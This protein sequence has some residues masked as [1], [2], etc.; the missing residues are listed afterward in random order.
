[1][2]GAILFS[3]WIIDRRDEILESEQLVDLD[4]VLADRWRLSDLPAIAPPIA[5]SDRPNLHFLYARGAARI[6]GVELVDLGHG[7]FRFELDPR[8]Q[9]IPEVLAIDLDGDRHERRLEVVRPTAHPRWIC[10][11]GGRAAAVSTETDELFLI[12]AEIRRI[13]VEDRPT[14]CAVLE[15]GIAVVHESGA[16]ILAGTNVRIELGGPL[17]HAA[18]GASALAVSRTDP[19]AIL[20]LSPDLR[21]ES[22]IPLSFVPD[23]VAF[24]AGHLIASSA[25]DR[26]LVI[27]R[28]GREAERLFLGRPVVTMALSPDRSRLYAAVTDYRPDDDAGPNHHVEDQILELEARSLRILRRFPTAPHASPVALSTRDDGITIAFAGSNEVIRYDRSFRAMERFAF[29]LPT[30]VAELGADPII[31]SAAHAK[32]G[33]HSF[34]TPDP[35]LLDGE[36]AFHRATRAGLSCQT[37]HLHG[38]SDYSLHDIGHGDAR[39]TLSA[40]ATARTA[41]Y[42]RGASYPSIAALEAFTTYVLGGYEEPIPNRALALEAYL[43]SLPRA[44][45]RSSP[46]VELLRR[47]TDAFVRAGCSFCHRFP[48]FTDLAQ[49]PEGF[50]F[51]ERS[52]ERH[53]LDTPSLL[54][55]TDAAP[56]LYD[57]RAR[58]LEQVLLDENR[59]G[60]HG[61]AAS[62]STSDR[63]ALL[64]FLRSL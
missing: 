30:G 46:D 53:L 51:P 31:T 8:R 54:G 20:I 44:P 34:D 41:P 59:S 57:G 61:D 5:H 38:G 55:V 6:E 45:P 63:E 4:L 36:R 56:Y 13:A 33:S 23:W 11:G 10:T 43:A 7:L 58:T 35:L 64:Y 9:P 15:D 16:A 42:L 3:Y 1:V 50:L 2:A 37:C 19:P 27:L 26:S 49:Y 17:V 25:R 47:G 24:A 18:A 22:E 39:P 62:L 48:A 12:G 29:D 28:E 32:I 40:R 14:D 52:E 60:R 21:L